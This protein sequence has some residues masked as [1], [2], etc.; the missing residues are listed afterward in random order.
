MFYEKTSVSE[1]LTVFWCY[2]PTLNIL[3]HQLHHVKKLLH[4]LIRN[5]MKLVG[6][7]ILTKFLIK[8]DQKGM[9][10]WL[11]QK[12]SYLILK[13]VYLDL[14]WFKTVPRLSYLENTILNIIRVLV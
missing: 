4:D 10:K 14:L 11:T 6:F 13:R 7:I 2:E 12:I 9:P 5:K 1:T 3:S 8:Q